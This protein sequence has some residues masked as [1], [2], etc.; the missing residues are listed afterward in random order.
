MGIFLHVLCVFQS[1]LSQLANSSV[2]PSVLPHACL[3]VHVSHAGYDV[4][5]P[6]LCPGC[7][8]NMANSQ[9]IVN[10][11]S[12]ADYRLWTA[13]ALHHHLEDFR[14]H[15]NLVCVC[16]SVCV[17]VSPLCMSLCA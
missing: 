16:M 7:L 13:P 5:G 2:C 11:L 14:S 1:L 3:H 8:T 4:S 10:F 6:L 12:T 9:S 17:C 15:C